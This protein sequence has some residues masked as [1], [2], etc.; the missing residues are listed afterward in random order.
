M[1]KY[2]SFILLFSFLFFGCSKDDDGGSNSFDGSI[3]SISNFVGSDIL[4]TMIDL[5]MNIN[6]GDNPPNIVGEY[7]SSPNVLE[8]SNVPSD[9]PGRVFSDYQSEFSNQQGLQIDFSGFHP[10]GNQIDE[11]YGSFISGDGNLFS[12]FLITETEIRDSKADTVIVYSGEISPDGI[13]SY[14][15]AIFMKDNHGNSTVFLENGQGRIL[16]DED[17]L[18]ERI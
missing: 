7:L 14:Q 13:Y 12:V 9:W 8:N 4:D 16:V 15:R 1:K 11:G 18:A 5:G 17:G 2:F 10:T 3:N 6:S